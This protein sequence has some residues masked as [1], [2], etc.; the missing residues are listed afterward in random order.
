MAVYFLLSF[1]GGLHLATVKLQESFLVLEVEKESRRTQA[2]DSFINI[3]QDLKY[4]MTAIEETY[5]VEQTCLIAI[6]ELKKISGFVKVMVYQFDDD[7]NGDVIAEEMEAGMESYLGLK[8]PASDIPR[9]ARELYRKISYRIIPNV[10]YEPVRLYPVINPVSNGFTDL[11]DSN[12]RSVAA[13]HLEYLRNMKVAASMSTRVLFNGQ[14]WGLIACHH[15]TPKYLSFEMCAVFEILSNMISSR[16]SALLSQD[17]F[18][19]KTDLQQRHAELVDKIYTE[20]G[21]LKGLRTHQNDLLQLLKAEG[22]AIVMNN[23]VECFGTA[24]EKLEVEDLVMWLQ[25]HN[26]HKIYHQ[27]SLPSV[28]EPAQAYSAGASG[29]LALPVQVEKGNFILA[30]RPEAV[31][32]V[33]WGGNPSEAV[34]FEPDGKKYHPR[35]SFKLWQ[36]VVEKTSVPWKKEDLEVAERFRNFVVEF[37]LN[38]MYN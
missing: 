4:I 30:F 8:F 21:L 9:Q 14:L 2:D 15:R 27:P 6:R 17:A 36:Q 37:A 13:V 10:E 24:P 33:H 22:I 12:L 18:D 35:A 3:Y 26:V 16:I 28:Y 19:Y 7:W 34:N 23:A 1:P 25:S 38:K 20:E 5:T 31:K 32:T 29:V 11:S